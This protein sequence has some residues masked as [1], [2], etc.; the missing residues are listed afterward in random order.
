MLTPLGMS[1]DKK[2]LG[3]RLS[4]DIDSI[5]VR[6]ADGS[7]YTV[8]RDDGEAYISNCA[9]VSGNSDGSLCRLMFNSL[10]NIGEVEEVEIEGQI[11]KVE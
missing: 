10:V 9:Y 4:N 11:F 6:F 1:V 5:T 3:L 7:E 2:A 8:E